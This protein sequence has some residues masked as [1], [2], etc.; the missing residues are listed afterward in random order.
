M[1]V[2]DFV[3]NTLTDLLR[4]PVTIEQS[5]LVLGGES[6]EASQFAEIVNQ[7]YNVRLKV[8]DIFE[9]DYIDKIIDHILEMIPQ[10]AI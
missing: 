8:K 6:F 9:L 4:T 3:Q 1:N 2:S 5:F 7:K 10:Q